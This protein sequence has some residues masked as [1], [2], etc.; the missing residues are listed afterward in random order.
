MS[1]ASW[2]QH[3]AELCD[4]LLSLLQYLAWRYPSDI[5]R[6]TEPYAPSE[7]KHFPFDYGDCDFEAMRAACGQYI[8][9]PTVQKADDN[10]LLGQLPAQQIL[11]H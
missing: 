9:R 10:K 7:V 5:Q 8:L 3:V 11:E 1:S 6:L 4:S 2:D